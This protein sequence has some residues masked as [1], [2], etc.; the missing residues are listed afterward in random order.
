MEFMENMSDKSLEVLV[1]RRLRVINF[2]L[3]ILLIFK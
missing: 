2:K 1:V 3:S